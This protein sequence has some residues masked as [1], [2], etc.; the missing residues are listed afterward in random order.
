MTKIIYL[1]SAIILITLIIDFGG[2]EAID[3][4]IAT[5]GNFYTIE[6]DKNIGY[7]TN[8]IIEQLEEV[9]RVHCLLNCGRVEE[10][11]HVAF[12]EALKRCSLLQE[13][14]RMSYQSANNN[15]VEDDTRIYSFVESE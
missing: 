6:G 10:C 7:G 1:V 13:I 4:S 12:N 5:S 9:S 14:I 2:V 3:S 8:T 15:H 11:N